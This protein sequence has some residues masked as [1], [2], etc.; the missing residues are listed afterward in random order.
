MKVELTEEQIQNT[1]VF[2]QRTQLQG[3]EVPA[4]I[5]IIKALEKPLDQPSEAKDQMSS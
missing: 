2:L 5:Q 4:F 1:I 3:A